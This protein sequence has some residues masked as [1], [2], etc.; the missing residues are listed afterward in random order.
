MDN[1]PDIQESLIK[2]YR[3]TNEQL[4][5]FDEKLR[6]RTL[7]KGDYLLKAGQV[8]N[9]LAFVETGSLRF[10]S[11]TDSDEL[12]LH[13]FTEGS[14]LT[15]YE[16]LISQTPSENHLQAMETTDVKTIYLDDLHQLLEQYP[17]FKNIMK[18]LD[19][20]I[21][22]SSH[23]KSITSSS[24]DERYRLLLKNHPEWINRFPQMH[25][26]SYLGMTKET[27]SRVK[28]RVR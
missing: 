1:K 25:I 15:D 28:A 21:I 9:F 8:C 6:D 5:A 10:Y 27:F 23:L 4:N 24:P 11:W 22:T 20:S 14:W 13:F 12:T 18:V 17:E 2:A 19:K 26:A 16:S 3:F 7:A